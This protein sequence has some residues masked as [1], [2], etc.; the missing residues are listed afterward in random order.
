MAMAVAALALAAYS[1][2]TDDCRCGQCDTRAAM[3]ARRPWAPTL[4][5]L[6]IAGILVYV[7]L[8]VALVF[9]RSHFSVLHN[10]ESDYG[11]AGHTRGSWIS[12]SCCAARSASRS[13]AH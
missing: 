3:S 1:P 6:A 4:A 12:T 11:S 2:R 13:L 9:L 10:A 5:R 8:D 7:A